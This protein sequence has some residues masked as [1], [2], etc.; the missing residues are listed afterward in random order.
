MSSKAPQG[1]TKWRGTW[2]TTPI[3]YIELSYSIKSNMD[4]PTPEYTLARSKNL[5]INDCL[6]VSSTFSVFS[7]A[8]LFLSIWSKIDRREQLF[9]LS[10][11]CSLQKIHANSG[12]PS[13]L[14]ALP[15]LFQIG[16]KISCHKIIVFEQWSRIWSNFLLLPCTYSIYSASYTPLLLSWSNVSILTQVAS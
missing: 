1:H 14:S 4:T 9:K 2:K 15:T 8:H 11:F 3:H 10:F 6:S 13:F 5:Y 16:A 12:A 7:N